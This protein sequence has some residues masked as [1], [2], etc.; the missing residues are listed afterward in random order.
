MNTLNCRLHIAIEHN[1]SSSIKFE[2]EWKLFFNFFCQTR[3]AEFQSIGL[4]GSFRKIA[5]TEGVLGFYRWKSESLF[6]L[7][8]ILGSLSFM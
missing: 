2:D 4:L 1:L 6:L 8:L 5:K 3:K 7:N